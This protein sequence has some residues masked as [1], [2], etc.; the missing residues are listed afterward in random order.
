MFVF[1]KEIEF[2]KLSLTEID[3]ILVEA[4][5]QANQSIAPNINET[6]KI[7]G[8]IG[9]LWNQD[10]EYYKEAL[11]LLNCANNFSPE[12]NEQS[13]GIIP[14][15]FK[16]ENLLA[17][18]RAELT[19]E[20]LL[21]GFGSVKNYQGR[22]KYSSVGIVLH[23]TAGNIF[24]GAIDSLIMAVL[25]KNVSIV[26]VSSN[27]V[28]FCKLFLKSFQ[29]ADSELKLL[30]RICFLS[31]KGG[32]EIIE[33]KI[34]KGINLILAWGGEKMVAGYR[35]NLPQDVVLVEHGPKI[36]FHVISKEFFNKITLS[37]YTNIA[38]DI[39]S[40]DQSACSNSQNIFI[41]SGVDVRKFI[42]NLNCA[43]SEFP[44]KIHDLSIHESSDRESEFHLGL[45]QEFETGFPVCRGDSHLVHYDQMRYL[46]TTG[47]NRHVKVKSFQNINQLS[48][49]LLEFSYYLQTCGLGITENKRENYR[50]LLGEAGVNR[51]TELGKMTEGLIGS[52]HDGSYN[53]IDLVRVINDES[54]I[55]IKDFALDM[56]SKLEYYNGL[57]LDSFEDIPL[58]DGVLLAKNSID[59]SNVFLNP[60][61][62]AGKIFSSG[63]TTGNPKY[64]FYENCEFDLV[65]EVLADTYRQNGLG[66]GPME[67]VGNLFVAG[68]MWSSFSIIQY[69]LDKLNVNQF[70]MGGMINPF[71]F[72]ALVS[73]FKI[74][75]LFGLPSLLSDFAHA[76]PGL[77]IDCV[78]YA[79]ESFSE[80]GRELLKNNWGCEKVVSAGYASVDVGPIGYQD[81]TCTGNEHY[82]LD[83]LVHLEIIN[84]EAVITS[85]IRKGMPVIRYQ[86][87]DQ[88]SLVNT[89]DNSTDTRIKF[90]LFGRVDG[91]INI[92]ACRFYQ[93]EFELILNNSL[94]EANYQVLMES[95]GGKEYI[96]I[97][98]K[99]VLLPNKA[100][101]IK[102]AL[103][104][105][106]QDIKQTHD[107]EYFYQRLS[108]EN[109]EFLSNKK[110]GKL[111]SFFDLRSK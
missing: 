37:D 50:H 56:C 60:K 77:K 81:D 10:G 58:I 107:L 88:V 9:K 91:Q 48:K 87:G 108:F 84:G 34:K 13:L 25:T 22:V 18:V 69:A 79:G 29:E 106:C 24:L 36:S 53:L 74:T 38:K 39:C 7:L 100:S 82:L 83:Q 78:Y 49:D 28:A 86:T 35:K 32:N 67:N 33:G 98:T 45:F 2:K 66:T 42:L 101:T 43:L 16:K 95:I 1:G 59:K 97:L 27:N 90:N 105:G 72:K 46:S 55:D 57:N 65:S 47:L 109:T 30:T 3:S 68:N 80:A 62:G 63:G 12:M 70:P 103:Y 64:C 11:R 14:E 61:R 4:K 17:R 110:T 94:G 85:K 102:D 89:K 6:L 93:S 23:I 99:E 75:T 41:E 111:K 54:Q 21:D 52:P 26:K 20:S 92:W 71:E 15:L 76:T 104:E 96:R 40:W 5:Q 8:R 19:D 73:K 44:I 31:W 51:F